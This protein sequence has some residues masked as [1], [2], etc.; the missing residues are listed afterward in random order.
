MRIVLATFLGGLVGFD[1]ERGSHPAGFR[2]NILVC[3]GACLMTIVSIH[4]FEEYGSVKDPARLAAQI[5]SG[6]GFLGAGVILHKG[7]SVR[8]L[9]T[10]ASMWAV[11]GIGITSGVG[12]LKLATATTVLVTFVLS[13]SKLLEGRL[14]SKHNAVLQVYMIKNDDAMIDVKRLLSKNMIMSKTF[15]I[16]YSGDVYMV[17]ELD[18]ASPQMEID[19]IIES[20]KKI[21]GITEVVRR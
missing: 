1:R 2:T 20:L 18:V 9:T 14:K 17:L 15:D 11:A 21:K 7:V 5:V 4:G 6:I 19:E 10:A 3:V 13:S 8:G 12:M 16:V